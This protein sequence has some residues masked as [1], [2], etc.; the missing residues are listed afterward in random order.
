MKMSVF[1]SGLSVVLGLSSGNQGEQQALDTSW[2]RWR[3]GGVRGQCCEGEKV[4]DMLWQSSVTHGRSVLRSG[5]ADSDRRRAR[6]KVGGEIIE[7]LWLAS[8]PTSN[9]SRGGD[10]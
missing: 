2:L 7:I 3:C 6:G 9:G 5:E 10:H 4:H 1:C 8:W